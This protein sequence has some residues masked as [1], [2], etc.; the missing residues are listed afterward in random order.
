MCEKILRDIELYFPYLRDKILDCYDFGYHEWIVELKN[1]DVVIFD[2]EE[3]TIRNVDENKIDAFGIR[4]NRIMNHKGVTQT[5]LSRVTG[6]PQSQ[7]S[8]YITGR[9]SP[10]FNNVIKIVNALD[11]SLEDFRFTK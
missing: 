3:K 2:V 4:L 8:R 5:E 1:G 7:L 9:N 10:T 11:C 6:I